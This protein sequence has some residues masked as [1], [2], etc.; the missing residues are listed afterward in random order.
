MTLDYPLPHLLRPKS[1]SRVLP[2]KN[3]HFC[4]SAI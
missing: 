1:Y 2:R 3:D 4:H